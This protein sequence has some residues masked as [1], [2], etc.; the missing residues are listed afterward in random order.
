VIETTRSSATPATVL[1]HDFP[2][3]SMEGA[4]GKSTTLIMSHPCCKP[5]TGSEDK[6]HTYHMVLKL[7]STWTSSHNILLLT[8]FGPDIL[9]KQ[10]F[11]L[12]HASLSPQ[13]GCQTCHSP[14]PGSSH[15]Y[16]SSLSLEV[17]PD[18]FP[19]KWP[20]LNSKSH[21]RIEE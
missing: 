1:K 15:S 20:L 12:P 13:Q 6:V 5:S 9:N 19:S 4:E 16:P 21:R 17:F 14:V 18:P 10:L 7:H 11:F 2:N 3:K 8:E